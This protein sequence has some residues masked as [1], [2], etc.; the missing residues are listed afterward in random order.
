MGRIGDESSL[1]YGALIAFPQWQRFACR[2]KGGEPRRDG[3]TGETEEGEREGERACDWLRV[4]KTDAVT[5]AG[6]E[7]KGQGKKGS[8]EQGNKGDEREGEKGREGG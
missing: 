6:D 8:R 7:R 4:G 2:R 5:V 1:R 3:H